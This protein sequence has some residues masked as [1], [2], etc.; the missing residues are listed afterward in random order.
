MAAGHVPYVNL[1]GETVNPPGIRRKRNPRPLKPR[2]VELPKI[3]RR[4]DKKALAAYWA[5]ETETV[6]YYHGNLRPDLKVGMWL[7]PEHEAATGF[8]D[9]YYTP[10][11]SLA[12]QYETDCE[13]PDHYGRV[14]QTLPFNGRPDPD[15]EGEFES[16][17]VF[18]CD[19]A[20]IIGLA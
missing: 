2:K 6:E 16:D 10:S 7:Y 3:S 19:K 11:H 12:S 4:V 13:A 17:L 18:I 9:L 5:D 14:Y 15:Y 20:L 8:D 1:F